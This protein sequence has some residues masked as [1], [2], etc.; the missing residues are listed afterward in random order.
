MGRSYW[1]FQNWGLA[2]KAPP[3]MI[4][5]QAPSHPLTKT[6]P[7]RPCREEVLG[8]LDPFLSSDFCCQEEEEELKL[9]LTAEHRRSSVDCLF[10]WRAGGGGRIRPQDWRRRVGAT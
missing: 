5:V 9:F 2:R 4:F 1:G 3:G 7:E 10:L 8:R 6:D